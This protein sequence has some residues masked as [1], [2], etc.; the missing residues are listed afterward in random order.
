MVGF[1]QIIIYLLCVY[2]VYKGA[3]IFQIAWVSQ[4]STSRI[5]GIV[6]GILATIGAVGVGA[7]AVYMTESM[8]AK[9]AQTLNSIPQI[10]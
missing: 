6:I 8:A 2:L 5:I 4:P 10:K 9:M 3:E 7:V 1:L